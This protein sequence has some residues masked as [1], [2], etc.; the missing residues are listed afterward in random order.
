MSL[1]VKQLSNAFHGLN[2]RHGFYL[3]ASYFV[4]VPLCL[5]KPNI[6]NQ[7]LSKALNKFF[8]QQ[9]LASPDRDIAFA[10]SSSTDMIIESPPEKLLLLAPGGGVYF[11]AAAHSANNS[12][13]LRVVCPVKSLITTITKS[14][15]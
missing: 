11:S 4:T 7:F 13:T 10:A 14:L 12:C 2:A 1:V 15:N 3:T 8:S 6:A 9:A 5:G